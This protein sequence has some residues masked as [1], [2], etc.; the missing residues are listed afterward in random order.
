M[1]TCVCILSYM[2]RER[3]KKLRIDFFGWGGGRDLSSGF[4][5]YNNV[6]KLEGLG[7][8]MYMYMYKLHVHVGYCIS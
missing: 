2:I 8:Y 3:R 6:E 7:T 5:L 1:Y 4:F